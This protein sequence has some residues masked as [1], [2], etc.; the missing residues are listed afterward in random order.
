MTKKK[1]S[2][3]PVLKEE[4]ETQIEN[5]EPVLS[6]LSGIFIVLVTV[7][8]DMA[9]TRFILHRW[10]N[11]SVNSTYIMYETVVTV[12]CSAGLIVFLN[13]VR[14]SEACERAESIDDFPYGGPFWFLAANPVVMWIEV[15]VIIGMIF[16]ALNTGLFA[17]L[18]FETWNPIVFLI[19]KVFYSFINCKIFRIR[20]YHINL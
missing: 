1:A 10:E 7:I 16:T 17:L 20:K 18:G 13:Y 3:Q 2:H 4:I 9:I 12:V 14:I 11:L 6:A 8:A 15:S 19:Y 5:K